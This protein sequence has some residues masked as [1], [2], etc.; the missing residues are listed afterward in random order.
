MDDLLVNTVPPDSDLKRIGTQTGDVAD[1]A[2]ALSPEEIARQNWRRYRYVKSRGH[3]NYL[4]EARRN[5]NYYLGGGLQWPAEIKQ[6]MEEVEGRPASEC[7][8]IMGAV[9]SAVGYQIANRMDVQFIPSSSDALDTT[10]K[11]LS[12]VTKQI[13]ESAHYKWHETQLFTDGLVQQ[14]GY[15]DI[16]IDMND[17]LQGE[18]VFDTLDPMDVIP[19][20]DAKSYDPKDWLDVTVTRWLTKNEAMERYGHDIKAKLDALS[21]PREGD[22]GDGDADDGIWRSRFGDPRTTSAEFSP[23]LSDDSDMRYRF[24]DRQHHRYDF[25]WVAV[26]PTGE[27]RSIENITEDELSALRAQ[28]GVQLTKRRIKRVRWTVSA[29]QDVLILD[30]W[31]PW[32]TFSIVPYFPYFRRGRTRGLVDN[33]I[34]PQD[35]LNKGISQSIAIT[36]GVSNSGMMVEQNSLTNMSTADLEAKGAQNGLILEY[37]E[38]ATKPEKIEPNQV[39]AGIVQII[40]LASQNI[41]ATTGI[42]EALTGQGQQQD[43]SGVAI[44]SRQFMAQQQLALPLDNLSRSRYMVAEKSLEFIQKFMIDERVI[45]SAPK[46][47]SQSAMSITVNKV[48]PDGSILHD[49]TVGTYDVVVTDQPM[50]ITFDN[51]QFEQIKAFREI[52]G[53]NVPP[54][55]ALRYSNLPDKAEIGPLLDQANGGQSDPVK[56]AEAKLKDSQAGLADANAALTKAKTVQTLATAIYSGT[57]AAAQAAAIPHLAP[58]ADEILAAAGF[59]SASGGQP[60]PADAGPPSGLAEPPLSPGQVPGKTTMPGD[61]PASLARLPHNTDP[62][63]PAHPDRGVDAG[64]EGG[65]P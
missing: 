64:I 22:F 12:M 53:F 42:N 46:D 49:L 13:F 62:L 17:N 11:V 32:K 4:A 7:N 56:D 40:Q 19:D 28:P 55:V 31:S 61:P 37:K 6:Y 39:P 27:I 8:E 1:A 48:Q 43:M 45:R 59:E 50:Q 30:V 20:P 25:A 58:V 57:Q 63:T 33:A 51:S 52:F 21:L 23:D 10:A 36:N 38:G 16:R 47:P 9:N 35:T 65:H 34:S 60:I 5:E 54:S 15:L 29:G 3:Q 24:I 41:K 14:R 18:L 44:Q 2:A 26:Y